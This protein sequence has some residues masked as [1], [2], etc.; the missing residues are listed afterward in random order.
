MIKYEVKQFLVFK[1]KDISDVLGSYE[2]TSDNLG[3][4]NA[5]SVQLAWAGVDQVDGS[6][7]VAQ[8]NHTGF[9]YVDIPTLT[10]NIDSA[11][12][13]VILESS[14]FCGKD[15]KIVIDK[16]TATSGTY[17]LVVLAKNK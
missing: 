7:K 17:S 13:S 10:G 8:R 1:D 14:E 5:I 3:E 2:I 16:G 9:P 6:I 11:A 15:I 4:Y 12:S